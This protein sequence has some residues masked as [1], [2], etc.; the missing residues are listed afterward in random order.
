MRTI[1]TILLGVFFLLGL[2]FSS[3]A[4]AGGSTSAGPAHPAS[5]YCQKVGIAVGSLC[6]LSDNSMIEKFTLWR[7][8]NDGEKSL[9]VQAFLHTHFPQMNGPEDSWALSYCFSLGGQRLVEPEPLRPTIKHDLCLFA[10]R[11]AIEAWT[12]FRGPVYY[13][14]LGQLL[15]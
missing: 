13:S 7:R 12:L 9:A 5:I 14:G 6:V 8:K 10:D 3:L 1:V 15:K 4:L 11:S 2:S